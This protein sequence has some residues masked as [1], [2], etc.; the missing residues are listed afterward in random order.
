LYIWTPRGVEGREIPALSAAP[1]KADPR[2]TT[3]TAEAFAIA[4]AGAVAAGT[5]AWLVS[6]SSV[7]DQ[8]H[9]NGILRGLIVATYAAVGAYT[10]W[11][12]PASR[13][14]L[15]I[16]A[17]GLVVALTSLNA[18][19]SPLRYS[20]GRATVAATAVLI[21]Y[22]ALC[23]PRD[24]LGSQFE[25]R[26]LAG[27]VVAT[28]FSWALALALA[29]TLPPAGPF[30]QCAGRCPRNP[31]QL[32]GT[33]A[34]TTR[35]IE[36]LAN[37]ITVIAFVVIA[38]VLIRKTRSPSRLRRRA[39][40]PLLLAFAALAISLALFVTLSHTFG[41]GYSAAQR[42]I[43]AASALAIPV[44]LLV[45]QIRGN[46]FA[47]QGA[48]RMAATEP[49][50][51]ATIERLIS[52]ALGD[53]SLALALWESEPPGYVDVRGSSVELP[54]DPARRIST[55]FMRDGRPA[56]ALIH[57][58]ALDADGGVV[59]GL[60]A[61]SLMLLENIR[62]IEELRNSRARIVASVEHERLRL[63]RDLHDGAQQRLLAI[64]VKLAQAQ[65]RAAGLDLADQLE[66][67]E[68]DAEEAVEE[69]RALAHG[70]YPTVLRE[71]GVA[72][73][74]RSVAISAPIPIQL[75]DEGLGR[76]LPEIEAAIYF[77]SLE[78][79]QN[80]IKHAGPQARVTVSLARRPGEIE[81]AIG[82]DGVGIETRAD[83]DSVG[84][85]SIKDRI[86]AVGGEL[87]IT[88]SPDA[89]TRI[90]GLVPDESPFLV[91]QQSEEARGEKA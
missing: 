50:D 56:A 41:P 54:D 27:F 14:G 61:T 59:E 16:A 46:Y 52:D 80:A 65:K 71:R 32:V 66:A 7:L 68:L 78:A 67:I 42:T 36:I 82:D 9:S 2:A 88:S 35:A 90:R 55:L 34:A 73:A 23:F 58:P 79:I 81:F 87:E 77:C 39:V 3:R 57:D 72:D 31:F 33:S 45:G 28:A 11:R 51:S 15:L 70:I 37:A 38:A 24:R 48:G 40:T 21:G 75:T 62:L 86:G 64:Q 43:A 18:S 6:R 8:P 1:V 83:A 47:A 89:G 53:P 44:G 85:L 17:I 91:E 63:E 74:L 30:A 20:L 84:L 25:R 4:V 60:V 13:L 22:V 10:W 26:F 12:R 19:A 69:L 5:T 29:E 76:C 49:L